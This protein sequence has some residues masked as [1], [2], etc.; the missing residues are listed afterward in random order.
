MFKR[1]VD[2]LKKQILSARRNYDAHKAGLA[3][4][5]VENRRETK[6]FTVGMR[7]RLAP[8]TL[9]AAKEQAP[10]VFD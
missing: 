7:K 1:G 4:V 8:I 9:G 5:K 10:L 2:G 3:N 6:D